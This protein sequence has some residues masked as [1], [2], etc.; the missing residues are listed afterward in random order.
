MMMSSGDPSIVDAP[1][2][3]NPRCD[4][5]EPDHVDQFTDNLWFSRVRAWSAA[6]KSVTDLEVGG[7]WSQY[8]RGSPTILATSGGIDCR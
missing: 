6:T 5:A 7:I 8:A 1:S 4:S 2:I 3:V